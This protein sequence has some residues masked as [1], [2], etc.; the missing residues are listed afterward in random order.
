MPT[1]AREPYFGVFPVALTPF[2][3]RFDLDLVG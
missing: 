3:D 2:T 1:L